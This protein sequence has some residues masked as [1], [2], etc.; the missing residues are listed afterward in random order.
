[1]TGHSL[2]VNQKHATIINKSGKAGTWD[3]HS[4]TSWFAKDEEPGRPFP[5][6]ADMDANTQIT[7][8]GTA[9]MMIRYK[10]D[11][12]WYIVDFGKTYEWNGKTM[13]LKE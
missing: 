9:K 7:C 1:M 2:W 10:S 8:R 12:A 5:F 4:S 11:G 13:K 3:V 6:T